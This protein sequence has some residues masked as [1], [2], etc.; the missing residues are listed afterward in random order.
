MD[1]SLERL[2]KERPGG[3]CSANPGDRELLVKDPKGAR[4]RE[5]GDRELGPFFLE[6]R[7]RAKTICSCS[8]AA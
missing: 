5:Y 7:S 2:E 1:P 3:E 4:N 6:D 8:S